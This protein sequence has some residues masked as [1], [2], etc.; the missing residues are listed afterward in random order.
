MR[1][2]MPLHIGTR[3]DKRRAPWAKVKAAK[4]AA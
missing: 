4:K 1:F 3:S 2:Y